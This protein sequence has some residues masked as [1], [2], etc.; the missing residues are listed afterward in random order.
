MAS[1]SS[2]NGVA[3]VAKLIEKV[4]NEEKNGKNI[5]KNFYN[6]AK[7]HYMNAFIRLNF[8]GAENSTGFHN[9]TE[10]SRILGDA[11]AYSGK[12]ESLLRQAL[13]KAGVNVPEHINL[14]LK[15]YVNNRGK[16]KLNFKA[17]QEFKDPYGLQ[18]KFL[19]KQYKGI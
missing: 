4:H 7:D 2:F 17:N 15:K 18:D 14:E 12:A 5:D 13:A 10:A 8:I 16:K 11:L 1:P 9:S 6:K 19:P 3:T